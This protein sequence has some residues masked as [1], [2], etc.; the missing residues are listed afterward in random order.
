MTDLLAYV[1]AIFAGA[2]AGFLYFAGLW[3]TI[4]RLPDS[5]RPYLLL[6]ASFLLRAA[7]ILALF[8]IVARTGLLPLAVAALVFVLVRFFLTHRWGVRANKHRSLRG[9]HSDAG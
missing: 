8:Y 7:L 1:I 9:S 4:R 3:L 6:P 5:R 2:L